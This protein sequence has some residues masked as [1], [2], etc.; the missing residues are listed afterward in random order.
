MQMQTESLESLVLNV[1]SLETSKWQKFILL[2]NLILHKQTFALL[3]YLLSAAT[4][5]VFIFFN[6]YIFYFNKKKKLL[7]RFI[8]M[9]W[10]FIWYIEITLIVSIETYKEV[11]N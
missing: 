7:K 5:F 3:S 4:Y 6:I 8:L 1:S 10:M 11:L 2:A 9:T